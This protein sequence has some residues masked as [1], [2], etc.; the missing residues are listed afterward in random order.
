[1]QE[2]LLKILNKFSL[3]WDLINE[4]IID[5]N[6]FIFIDGIENEERWNYF[7]YVCKFV[8]Q[9]DAPIMNHV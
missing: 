2:H 9:Y 5:T 1:M 8:Y 4:N 7:D 3:R 6:T